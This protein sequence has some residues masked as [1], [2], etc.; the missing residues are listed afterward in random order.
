LLGEE[1]ERRRGDIWERSNPELLEERSAM[2]MPL[3]LHG[4]PR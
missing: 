1:R 3:L 2:L 4:R